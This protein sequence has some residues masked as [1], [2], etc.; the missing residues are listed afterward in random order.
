[1]CAALRRDGWD[2]LATNF[3]GGGGELDVVALRDGLLRVVEV[4]A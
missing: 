4:K 3:R 2:I 1:M